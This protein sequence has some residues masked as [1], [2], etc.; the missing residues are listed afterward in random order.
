MTSPAPGPIRRSRVV[1]AVLI[2]VGTIS[3][4]L[5]VLGLVLPILPTTPFLLL[6]AACYARASHRLHA[7]LLANRVFGPPIRDWQATRSMSRRVKWTA[8]AVLALT[9]TASAFL[10]VEDLVVRALLLAV[11]LVIAVF[12]FRIPTKD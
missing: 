4:G 2:A 5:A 3:L 11:G 8:I 6:A 9:I 7:A 12:L 10:F 1:R